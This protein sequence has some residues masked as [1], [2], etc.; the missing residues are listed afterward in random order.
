VR[1]YPEQR[2]PETLF[3]TGGAP[4]LALITCGD[5][6][7]QTSGQYADNVVAYATP[8]MPPRPRR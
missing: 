6:F 8:E 3:A 5:A 2:L 4:R 7:N 1:S